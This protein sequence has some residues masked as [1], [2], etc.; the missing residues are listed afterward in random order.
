MRGFKG[1]RRSACTQRRDGARGGATLTLQLWVRFLEG[2]LF[3][4]LSAMLGIPRHPDVD[5]VIFLIQLKLIDNLP[6]KAVHFLD[7]KTEQGRSSAL[8]LDSQTA[9]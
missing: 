1:T 4:R 6:G 2:S 3:P 7:E 8:F 5:K 9:G